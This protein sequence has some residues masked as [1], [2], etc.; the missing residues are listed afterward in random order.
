MRTPLFI[1]VVLWLAP[2]GIGASSV[3]NLP[4]DVPRTTL[5]A[6]AI[7]AKVAAAELSALDAI[8]LGIVEGVTEFLPI[9]STGHLIIV[10]RVLGLA[11]MEPLFEADGS[12]L[13]FRTPEHGRSGELLTTKLATDTY[14]VVI[15]FGAIAAV[16]LLYWSQLISMVRG[17]LGRDPAGRL[18]EDGVGVGELNYALPLVVIEEHPRVGPR[19]AVVGGDAG[20]DVTHVGLAGILHAEGRDEVFALPLREIRLPQF[21]GSGMLVHVTNDAHLG[22]VAGVVGGRGRCSAVEDGGQQD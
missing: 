11:S 2:L 9:S 15:Q 3:P 12:P 5:P 13:W 10:S 1:V 16:A 21:R 22:D 4:P 8:V 20:E 17:L 14:I 18:E 6:G 19:V 7:P